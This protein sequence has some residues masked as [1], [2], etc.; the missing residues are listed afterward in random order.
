L[1]VPETFPQY[2]LDDFIELKSLAEFGWYL[3]APFFKNDALAH[4]LADICAQALNFP[5]PLKELRDQ[6]AVLELF[7]G[8]T[9]AFK[10]IGARFLAQCF[11]HLGLRSSQRSTILVATSGDTGGAVAAAFF[12]QPL[13]EIGIL[14]PRGRIAERQEQQLTCWGENVHSFSVR[15]SFD[16]CQALVKAAFAD[17]EFRTRAHLTSANS[18]NI[19]RLLPQMIYYAW[20]SLS[21]QRQHQVAPGFVIPTG[22]VG[23]ALAAF[24]VQRM[25][26]PIR[27]IVI[28]TNSNRTIDDFLTTGQW[29]PR[30]SVATLANAMDVGN[31]SNMERL[32]RL[33]PEMQT[34]RSNC[35]VQAVSD[36]EIRTAITA[37]LARWG[38][39]WDPHTATAVTVRET[40]RSPH[41][42]IVATA[43]PA[44]FHTIVEPLVAQSVPVPPEL[45]ALLHRPRIYEEI[46]VDLAPVRA[47][48]L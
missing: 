43:H 18:I 5:I 14:F 4:Q 38:E 33:Y 3:L 20:A 11:H 46:D 41:W 2:D 7:H 44:K 39:I 30:P 23:N 27:E 1:Y 17:D 8:P 13:I 10:D 26:F 40:L 21:Y 22:N 28:A 24:W 9:A 15:G 35:R 45:A 25:G 36:D 31:P 6:T 19:G 42:I 12:R 48:F 47:L 34:L 32:R 16:D 29:Q 37:S